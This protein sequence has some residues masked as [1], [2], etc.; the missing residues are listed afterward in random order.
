[1]T[2]LRCCADICRSCAAAGQCTSAA[3]TAATAGCICT[4]GWGGERCDLADLAVLF[5]A[6]PIRWSGV[7]NHGE[8]QVSFRPG[9]SLDECKRACAANPL[10]RAVQYGVDENAENNWHVGSCALYRAGYARV[11]WDAADLYEMTGRSCDGCTA[12]GGCAGAAWTAAAGCGVCAE[13]WS[14]ELCDDFTGSEWRVANPEP[15]AA[16]I[17]DGA[18]PSCTSRSLTQ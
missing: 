11:D 16:A 13:G 18:H 2:C 3:W 17:A 7:S 10:C 14:G 5:D 1:M 6:S 12:A 9:L 15:Y 4:K 8:T